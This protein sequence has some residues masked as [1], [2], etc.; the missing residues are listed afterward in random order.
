LILVPPLLVVGLIV[1]IGGEMSA[2]PGSSAHSEVV[3]LRGKVVMLADVVKSKGVSS[4]VD[5]EPISKQVV[6]MG[7]DGTVTPLL[8]DDASRALFLDHRLRDRPAEIHG[9]RYPG[10]PYVQVM[11]FKVDRDGRLETAEYFCEVCAISVRFP[12][13]CPCCQGPMELRMKPDRR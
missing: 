1:A 6:L 13:T 7:D 8:S 2:P 10:M 4:K 3:T 9:R 12:Q 5:V 11:S